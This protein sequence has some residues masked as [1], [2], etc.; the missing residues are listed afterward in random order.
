MMEII[1]GNKIA[2]EIFEEL[3]RQAAKLREKN[4]LPLLKVILVGSHPASLSYIKTKRHT[5]ESVG[6][7]VEINEYPESIAEED[8]RHEIEVFNRAA[9]VDGILVQLPL[10]KSLDRSAVLDSVAPHLDVDCLTETNKQKLARGE[11]PAF[12]PPAPAAVLHTLDHYEVDLK[13]ANVLLVG[14]GELVGKPLAAMLLKRKVHYKIANRHTD[15]LS[16]LCR[17][18]DVVISGVGKAGLITKEMIKPGA[19]VI[20]AGTTAAEAGAVVGDVEITGVSGKA[21][22]FAPVPGGVGPVTVAMLLK[23][24]VQSAKR[25]IA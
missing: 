18:A 23:N 10:P 5:A 13:S 21:R 16:K 25:R 22:L 8:L 2:G 17:E 11:E 6:V 4:I 14:S 9:T 15:N 19:V 12:Y 7:I 24:V 20:D 1:N 3:R